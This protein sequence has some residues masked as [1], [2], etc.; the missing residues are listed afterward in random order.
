M[1]NALLQACSS[2]G[3]DPPRPSDARFLFFD[4]L[5]PY[6]HT[7]SSDIGH[8][9]AASTKERLSLEHEEERCW[10]VSSPQLRELRLICDEPQ[11]DVKDEH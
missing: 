2:T 5:R 3:D 4:D 11:R 6:H 1:S 10:F 9:A 8:R 7:Q